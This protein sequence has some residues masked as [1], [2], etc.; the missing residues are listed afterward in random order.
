MKKLI[1][2]AALA[3]IVASPAFAQ[4]DPN[5]FPRDVTGSISAPAPRGVRH[6]SAAA[7]RDSLSAY[8]RAASVATSYGDP[9]PN[10]QFQLNRESEEGVW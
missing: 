6:T 5:M 4:A 1:M 3:T 2:S 8:G 10:I 7:Q 9:D